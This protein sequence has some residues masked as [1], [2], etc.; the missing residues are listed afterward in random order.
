MQPLG[1][2]DVGVR[3]APCRVLLGLWRDLVKVGVEPIGTRLRGIARLPLLPALAYLTADAFLCWWVIPWANT[4]PFGQLVWAHNGLA[5]LRAGIALAVLGRGRLRAL[6]AHSGREL[7][8]SALVVCLGAVA[9]TLVLAA[10]LVIARVPL[11]PASLDLTAASPAGGMALLGY[12]VNS[13]L[14]APLSEELIDRGVLLLALPARTPGWVALL[15]SGAVFA[16]MHAGPYHQGGFPLFP[17]LGGLMT[18]AAFLLRS[19]LIPPLVIHASGNLFL[20]LAELLFGGFT[21][22]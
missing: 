17:L 22:L 1:R 13:L 12:A 19:S 9:T 2:D 11:G 4:L 15:A 14:L 7:R 8:W 3:S 6:F 21:A 18:A 10:V 20:E 5:L 16:L